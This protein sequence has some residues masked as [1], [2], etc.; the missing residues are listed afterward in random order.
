[1]KDSYCKNI[2]LTLNLETEKKTDE[3]MNATGDGVC[4][5]NCGFTQH[6][7]TPNATRD[8]PE[9][10]TSGCRIDMPVT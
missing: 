8:T 2:F 4:M 1:M 5:S 9:L 3:I 7:Q 10:C 6:N